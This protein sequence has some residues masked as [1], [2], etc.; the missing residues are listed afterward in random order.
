MVATNYSEDKARSGGNLGWMTREADCDWQNGKLYLL[1]N[2]LMET[3]KDILY[4]HQ[5]RSFIASHAASQEKICNMI[6]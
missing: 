4:C 6:F 5:V 1:M 3:C 2:G